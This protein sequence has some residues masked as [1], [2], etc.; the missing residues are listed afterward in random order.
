ML[1]DDSLDDIRQSSIRLPGN[2]MRVNYPTEVV[3][4]ATKILQLHPYHVHVMHEVEESDKNYFNNAE[5]LHISYAG[6]RYFR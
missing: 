4:K 1:S 6:Y 2:S 3:R 5:R